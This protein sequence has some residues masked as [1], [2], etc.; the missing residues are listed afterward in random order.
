MPGSSLAG[1]ARVRDQAR[2][3]PRGRLREPA[4]G[5]RAHLHAAFAEWLE[6]SREA[7]EEHAA[8]LAHHYAEAVRPEDVDLAWAGADS[9]LEEL[10]GKALHWLERAATLA[11]GRYEIDDGVTLY[12]RALELVDDRQVQT[13]IWHALGRA[14]AFKF[15]GLRFWDAMQKAIDLCD[16]ETLRADLY[17]DLALQ[18]AGRIG[19]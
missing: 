12:Q 16:D 3:D 2:P 5:A 7:R 18:T 6:R 15:D 17:A 8:L 14:Y 11:V 19:M 1:R 4:E 13:R 9:E 10:R